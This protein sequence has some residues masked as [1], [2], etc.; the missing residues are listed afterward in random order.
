MNRINCINTPQLHSKFPYKY[1]FQSSVRIY[2]PWRRDSK[3]SYSN[4]LGVFKKEPWFKTALG[5]PSLPTDTPLEE[6]LHP[7]YEPEKRL[8]PCPGDR[9]LGQYEVISKLGFGGKSKVKLTDGICSSSS[10]AQIS[11]I[12]NDGRLILS[13]KGSAST[14]LV[15]DLDR[16]VF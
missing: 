1:L 10:C 16:Y 9:I 11:C 15:R 14:W 7:Y 4:P 5:P 13:C 2:S 12:G 6:E 8:F 3:R